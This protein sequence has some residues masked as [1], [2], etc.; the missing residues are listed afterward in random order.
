MMRL[1]TGSLLLALALSACSTGTD[2]DRP[3]VKADSSASAGR[4]TLPPSLQT[5]VS[6]RM[7]LEQRTYRPGEEFKVRWPKKTL[8]GVAY[9]MDQWTG[10]DWQPAFYVSATTPEAPPSF[11]P[12]WWP[13]DGSGAWHDIGL[14]GTGPEVAV[15]P[16]LA[17]S[18]TYRLCTANAP[19]LSCALLE[20]A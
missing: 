9:S 12:R 6:G 7:E 13:V 14:G 17:E 11:G 1:G 8:R 15:V 5:S 10:G 16:D 3:E 20:V 2:D 19:R 18:G 4:S